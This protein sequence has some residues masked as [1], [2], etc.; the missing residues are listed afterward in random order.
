MRHFKESKMHCWIRIQQRILVPG[1]PYTIED[2]QKSRRFKSTF[3]Y[4]CLSRSKFCKILYHC[5]QATTIFPYRCVV[6]FLHEYILSVQRGLGQYHFQQKMNIPAQ[7]N[8]TPKTILHILNR[9][10]MIYRG[11]IYSAKYRGFNLI[12]NV[13]YPKDILC[14]AVIKFHH[15]NGVIYYVY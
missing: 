15:T 4:L 13:H 1:T 9:A 3:K 6:Y 7:Q 5:R 11:I 8:M 14:L 12:D 10:G 2:I